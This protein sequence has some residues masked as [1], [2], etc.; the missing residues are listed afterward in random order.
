MSE[1]IFVDWITVMGFPWF[2]THYTPTRQNSA[3][4]EVE[5]MGKTDGYSGLYVGVNV[6]YG[7]F[8]ASAK[9]SDLVL[10]GGETLAILPVDR[11]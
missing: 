11:G 5:L 2:P 3:Q 8:A 4:I 7:L 1:T 10:D 6:D 9:I